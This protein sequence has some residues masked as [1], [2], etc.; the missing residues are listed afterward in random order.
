MAEV[1]PIKWTAHHYSGGE[2]G[3][4]GRYRVAGIEYKDSKW[5]GYLYLWGVRLGW[6]GPDRD[7]M[8]ALLQQQLADKLEELIL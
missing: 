8:K 4:I 2:D 6:S 1:L 7:R 5:F 3:S